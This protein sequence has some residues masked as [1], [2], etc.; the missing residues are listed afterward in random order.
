MKKTVFL[1]ALFFAGITATFAQLSRDLMAFK[2]LE[3]TDK[4]HV[5]LHM[6]QENK[7]V[8]EGELANQMELTQTGDILRLKMGAGYPLQGNKVQVTLYS[9]DV[10]SIVARKGADIAL[11]KG[12]I[13]MDAIN[14]SAYEGGKIDVHVEGKNLDVLINTGGYIVTKGSTIAQKIEIALGGY[15]YGK[16]LKSDDA[17]ATISAGGRAEVHASKRVNI[18]TRAGGIVEVY[19]NPADRKQ[20]KLAG[21][22]INY[23]K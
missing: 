21:G 10:S 3:V 7:I 16:A 13:K 4:I 2:E 18:Q 11:E 1:V 22:K 8:I 5:Q 12:Q 14:L 20:K 15:Y 17:T 19:G 9:T 6:A 23:I